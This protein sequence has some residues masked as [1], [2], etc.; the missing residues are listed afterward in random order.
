M[1]DPDY[2][3]GGVLE[4][5]EAWVGI[6]HASLSLPAATVTFASTDDGQTGDW[7]QYMDLVLITYTRCDSGSVL[8]YL[9]MNENNKDSGSRHS[10]QWLYADSSAIRASA[11]AASTMAQPL[12]YVLGGGAAANEFSCT[13]TQLFDINSGKF[14]HG[15]TMSAADSE[16]DG[17]VL[18]NGIQW[19]QNQSGGGAAIPT[20][21]FEIDLTTGSDDF[22]AGSTFH[23]FGVLPRMVA[24]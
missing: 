17:E 9:R 4:D 24:P 22:V 13:I 12:G 10:V 14:G 1:A 23:L 2:I 7:S 8:G 15:L 21:L 5:T 18:L 6:A 20:A 19:E 3:V 11:T 16:G